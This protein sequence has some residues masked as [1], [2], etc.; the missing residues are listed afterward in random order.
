MSKKNKN[1]NI[2]QKRDNTTPNP[3]AVWLSDGDTLACVGYTNLADNPEIM[4]AC[5]KIAELIGSLTIHLMANTEKGDQRIINELS[6]KIDIEPEMHMTRTTWMQAIVMNLLLYG[7]GN[8]IV[9]PH[10][11]NG[12]LQNLEPISADRVSF[13]YI[14]Y[15]DY[16]V[17]IDGKERSPDN[18]LHFVFNP[19]KTYL[20][21]GKGL[22]VC[23]KD[24]ADNLKQAAKTEKGFMES[25]WKPS[26]IVKVD[27]LTEE[28]S[29]PTG[30][31]KLLDSYVESANVGEPWLI[32]AQQFDVEQVKPLSL[33]DLAISDTVEINKRTVAAILGVPPFLLGVGE[34]NKEAWNNFI[35]NTIKPICI[36]IQQELTKKLIVSEK[37][38]LKFN[39]LSLLDWDI[40]SIYEVFG[41]LA[42]KGI[43]TP[44][45][46]RDR[47]G[48]TQLEGLDT[49][50]ILENYIPVDDIG[51]QKKLNNG[52][53]TDE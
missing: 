48:M 18:L 19:D 37:M 35:Q 44:N 23:L 12:Y 40:K 28:F 10:T 47:V 29:N 2:Q 42:D 51:N 17:M 14:G 16:K 32:P 4:T 50:R 3:I 52:G 27:A 31:Q 24:L 49:L 33:A 21:K 7:K 1:R 20:W 25:K 6:R 41:G 26:V 30:W 9:V 39:V 5:H 43:V 38:Y 45:E 22:T 11:Y 8:S 46:V 34:Y 53:G 13:K 15:R 36:S